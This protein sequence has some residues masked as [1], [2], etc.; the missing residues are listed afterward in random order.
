MISAFYGT[1]F[2]V[3][4]ILSGF[5]LFLWHKHFDVNFTMIFTLIPI[6]CLGYF[7]TGSA[8]SMEGAVYGLQIVY[9]GGCFLQLMI[10]LAVFSL[11]GLRLNRWVKAGMLLLS[12]GM[13]FAAL[14]QG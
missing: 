6:A 11:C 10:L 8:K 9:I 3:S 12:T 7:L 13:Y 1:L 5:Y 4:L 2:V 14:T